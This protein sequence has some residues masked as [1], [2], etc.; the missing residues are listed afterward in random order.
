MNNNEQTKT[1]MV[2]LWTK[3]TGKPYIPSWETDIRRTFER[4]C[5]WTPPTKNGNQS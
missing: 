1:D 3:L 5:Q 2:K 4:V